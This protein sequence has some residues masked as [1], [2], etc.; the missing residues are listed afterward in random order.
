M[1]LE[2]NYRLKESVH[3]THSTVE[4]VQNLLL[5]LWNQI[6]ADM[7]KVKKLPR[8]AFWGEKFPQKCVLHYC[9]QFTTKGNFL[10][11]QA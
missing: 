8:A 4:T 11:F 9:F 1:K 7:R 2:R 6:K 5:G 3:C 10:D